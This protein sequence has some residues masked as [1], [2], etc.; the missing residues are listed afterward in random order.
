MWYADVQDQERMHASVVTELEAQVVKEREEG[1]QF[2][3]AAKVACKDK[4]VSLF[5]M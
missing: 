2:K 1:Q 4:L 5:H 3:A